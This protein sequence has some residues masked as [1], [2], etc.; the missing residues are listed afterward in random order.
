MIAKTKSKTKFVRYS[1]QTCTKCNR[2]TNHAIFETD[3]MI[4]YYTK[5]VAICQVCGKEAKQ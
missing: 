5:L 1:I 4:P 2:K 3:S